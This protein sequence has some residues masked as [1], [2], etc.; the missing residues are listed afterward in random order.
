MFYRLGQAVS[1]TDPAASGISIEP[2][3]VVNVSGPA[4]RMAVYV[5]HGSA[6]AQD[7]VYT[8]TAPPVS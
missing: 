8:R 4:A 2:K 5:A 6:S 7:F 3:G 1:A